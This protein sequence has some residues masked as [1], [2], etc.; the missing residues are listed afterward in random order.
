MIKFLFYTIVLILIGSLLEV[1]RVFF[2][3]LCFFASF[4]LF[5]IKWEWGNFGGLGNYLWV[6]RGSYVLLILTFWI[7]G[8]IIISLIRCEGLK[9]FVFLLIIIILL[10]FFTSINLI[11]IYL[12]FEISLIPTYLIIVYWGARP[13]RLRASFYLMVYILLIS[14]P[15]LYYIMNLMKLGTLDMRILMFMD[16]CARGAWDGIMIMGAFLVKLPVYLFH[17]WLPKAH[18]EA[19]VFGSIILA[20]ILL[21]LGGYGLYR[22]VRLIKI[23]LVVCQLV[24]RVRLAGSLIVRFL[25]IVQVDIKSLV[26]YS[27][28]VHIN[29]ML[30][31]LLTLTKM[32]ILSALVIIASH[33]LCSSGLFYMVNVYYD[34]SSR[35]LLVMN[36]GMISYLPSTAIWW[37][38]LCCSNF[39][40]P[41]SLNF[42]GEIT[43]IIVLLSWDK[44]LIIIVGMICFF[45]RAYSLYLFRYVQHG[46]SNLVNF[47]S[48]LDLKE[49]IVVT[50]HYFP[51]VTILIDLALFN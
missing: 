5:F 15:L 27:S 11:L 3:N 2:M 32:G 50:F 42:I 22:V 37:F 28:V 6:N 19:P 48:S 49:F 24:V 26:A 39:S 47:V 9:I 1:N 4:L 44:F 34:R 43:V 14:L 38:F 40:Y 29:L 46:S 33:G 31:G 17:L 41:L 12:F 25:R 10:I 18:V 21:K 51:L 36:K 35:R 20:A 8:L 23:N 30:A 16:L 7:V 13:E 45:R